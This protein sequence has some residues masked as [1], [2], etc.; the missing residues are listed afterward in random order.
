VSVWRIALQAIDRAGLGGT[1]GE[2][3]LGSILQVDVELL[4]AAAGDAVKVIA[5]VDCE[6]LDRA[7]L[8][9]KE[10]QMNRCQNSIPA[11]DRVGLS[12]WNIA[13]RSPS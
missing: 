13:G 3:L 9:L 12:L 8:A 10:K 4:A 7:S 11:R 5:L 2:P 1:E 6:A